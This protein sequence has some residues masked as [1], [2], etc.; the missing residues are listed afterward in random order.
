MVDAIVNLLSNARKYGGTPPV[1]SLRAHRTERGDLAFEVTDNGAGIPRA[2]HRRIFEKLYR[3][4]NR[5]SRTQ[6]GSGLG[7]AIVKHIVRAHKGRVV[8]ESAPGK[9][10]TFRILLTPL[11]KGAV[12]TEAADAA[13][14]QA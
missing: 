10:S 13:P 1:V 14:A 5:L 6:E 9:G 3:I 8:V 2:L 4:D 11:A 7:L 12:S